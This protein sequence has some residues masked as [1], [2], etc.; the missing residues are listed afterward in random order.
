MADVNH[1]LFA[2]AAAAW[3][4]RHLKLQISEERQRFLQERQGKQR[5]ARVSLPEALSEF[6]RYTDAAAKL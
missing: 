4:A 5:V 1:R 3:S 2:I 6:S